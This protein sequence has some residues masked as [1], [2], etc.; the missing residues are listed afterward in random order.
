MQNLFTQIWKRLS[1][2]IVNNYVPY[3]VDIVLWPSFTPRAEESLHGLQGIGILILPAI[4][5]LETRYIM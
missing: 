1:I 5:D 3:S 2:R 4:L